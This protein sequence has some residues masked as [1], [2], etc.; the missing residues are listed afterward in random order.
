MIE[1]FATIPRAYVDANL[2]EGSYMVSA[3]RF[4]DA[5][6]G[7]FR[8][9]AHIPTRRYFI[10]SGAFT[11]PGGLPYSWEKYEAFARTWSPA[12]VAGMDVF[13]SARST[14]EFLEQHP[15]L[16]NTE[17]P[18]VPVVTGRTP[19]EYG[20]CFEKTREF[21]GPRTPSLMA[22]GALK[23]QRDLLRIL[24]LLENDDGIRFH[25]F[26][27][28]LVQ[29]RQATR[30]VFSCDNGSW[31]GRFGPSIDAFNAIMKATGKTQKQVALE[32]ILPRYRQHPVFTI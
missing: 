6:R 32:I 16:V 4:W 5:P 2:P 3:S 29:L 1:F 22:V 14:V 25:L 30:Q 24:E 19:E 10:D 15:E 27:A 8:P 20:W 23:G 9:C 11:F 31:N 21:F 28:T 18:L 17:L 12:F 26:G 13:A 7:R